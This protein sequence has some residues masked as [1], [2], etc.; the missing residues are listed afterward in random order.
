[1]LLLLFPC[2]VA[3]F[4]RS[5]DLFLFLFLLDWCQAF[6]LADHVDKET[7]DTGVRCELGMKCCA[8][9]IALLHGDNAGLVFLGIDGCD[10]LYKK[11]RVIT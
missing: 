11:D 7:V 10:D 9:E 8:K 4:S 1:L 5:V 6:R 2:S 3:R